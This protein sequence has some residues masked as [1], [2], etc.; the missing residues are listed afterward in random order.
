MTKGF[1]VAFEGP[2]G[3]GK[4]S[5]IN[6]LKEKL[7]ESSIPVAYTREPGGS[8]IAEQIRQVL[9]AVENTAMDYRAEALLLA[10]SR[11][12]HLVETI[13]PN[14]DQGKLVVSD[15]FVM[16]SLAYQGMARGIGIDKVWQI[17][18][19]AIEDHLPDL[20]ILIDVP[21]EVGLE[22]IYQ[23]RGKRQF[24][25]L[26]RE[27]LE[28]HQRVRQ[29]YLDLAKNWQESWFLMVRKALRRLVKNV[30]VFCVSRELLVIRRN[31]YEIISSHCAR[32]RPTDF[33][34]SFS[35]E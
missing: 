20:T 27:A 28:F 32:S 9:L 6:Q 7:A 30:I 4:T 19:F 11:R 21:A 26:D 17:N 5:I 13:L 25:R 8:P 29:T 22:R 3:S 31:K 34:E 18:Q 10:A 12:Q 33:R 15:R 23:A 1:F 24:D 14:L 2:D 35:R 16:S